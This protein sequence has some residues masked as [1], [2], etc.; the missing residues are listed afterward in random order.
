MKD[1]NIGNAKKY[2]K[3]YQIDF[4][5]IHIV[6]LLLGNTNEY[7]R[8]SIGEIIKKK[9]KNIRRDIG[10]RSGDVVQINTL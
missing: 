9:W 7:T 8:G 5:V 10:R 6:R 3:R 1:V 4:T 2:L